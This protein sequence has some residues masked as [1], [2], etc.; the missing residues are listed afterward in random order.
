L[1]PLHDPQTALAV[2]A[3]RMVSRALGGSC[4]V[5]LAAHAV[6]RAGELYLTGRVSTTDGKRV[7]T[8]EECGAVVTV[9]DA[10]ALG[11]AVSDE[12]E[13]QGALD[14]VQALLASSQAAGK[15]DA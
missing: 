2:E 1:A 3:E 7:L 13:A 9:A 4:E 15:G 8:A 11:R 10:L 14:I 5:P 6:W 12:L